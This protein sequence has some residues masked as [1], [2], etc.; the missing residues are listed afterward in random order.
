MSDPFE[1][2]PEPTNGI[3]SEPAQIPTQPAHLQ[4]EPTARATPSTF[5]DE[6]TDGYLMPKRRTILPLVLLALTCVSTF[7]VGVTLWNPN[8]LVPIDSLIQ[9]KGLTEIR[10]RILA[11]WD[12]GL[13]YMASVMLILMLHE[14]GHFLFTLYYRVPASYPFFLPF[15]ANPIGTMGAV[16]GMQGAY[17]SLIHI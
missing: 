8:F 2:T 3:G 10:Q 11:H 9:G 7:W 12:S 6:L 5:Y 4:S 14:M 17:L 1:P 15:P 13:V 16:I